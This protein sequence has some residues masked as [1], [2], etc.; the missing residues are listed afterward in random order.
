MIWGIDSFCFSEVSLGS[1]YIDDEA[2]SEAKEASQVAIGGDPRELLASKNPSHVLVLVLFGIDAGL[3]QHH[4]RVVRDQSAKEDQER[5]PSYAVL[6]HS[7][8]EGQGACTH[9][10]RYEGKD[11]A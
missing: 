1:P 4:A 2:H 9:S 7:V 10:S 5:A 3:N 6:H 11:R 8:R